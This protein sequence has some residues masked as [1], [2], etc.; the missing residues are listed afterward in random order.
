MQMLGLG[1]ANVFDYTHDPRMARL[2]FNDDDFLY[3]T[4]EGIMRGVSC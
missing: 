2:G 4:G 1:G 3:F